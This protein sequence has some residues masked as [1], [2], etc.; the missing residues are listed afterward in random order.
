MRSTSDGTP[1]FENTH[2]WHHRRW[3]GRGEVCGGFSLVELLVLFAVIA[4]LASILSAGFRTERSNA[5]N[6]KEAS[7]LR[8]MYAAAELWSGDHGG[9]MLMVHRAE[10]APWE[11]EDAW[12]AQL[13]PYLQHGAPGEHYAW[14]SD[15]YTAEW[16]A[17]PHTHGN[18]NA[19]E[20]RTSKLTFTYGLNASMGSNYN[21]RYGMGDWPAGDPRL[22]PKMAEE[23]REGRPKIM[24]AP[25]KGGGPIWVLIHWIPG[26]GNAAS[27]TKF[28]S[29][30]KAQMLLTDGSVRTITRAQA[31]SMGPEHF[32]I[33][34]EP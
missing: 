32:R 33:P 23:V 7:K 15:F 4:V 34:Y 8:R 3:S 20:E 5:Q 21:M 6:A 31:E 22:A 9:K 24:I 10:S 30:G 13:A 28:D 19:E 12:V 17:N 2:G 25:K 27:P 26:Y 16:D 14:M 18:P 11:L 1:V 29:D